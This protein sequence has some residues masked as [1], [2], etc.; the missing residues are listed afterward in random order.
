M[1]RNAKQVKRTE[2]IRALEEVPSLTCCRFS[3]LWLMELF[4][5]VGEEGKTKKGTDRQTGRQTDRKTE[6]ETQRD[7]KGRREILR[8]NESYR[9]C[10]REIHTDTHKLR[11]FCL[12][13]F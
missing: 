11:L 3:S 12:V 7:T 9:M 6:T 1:H 5:V 8:D 13:G 10:R 2:D 4:I